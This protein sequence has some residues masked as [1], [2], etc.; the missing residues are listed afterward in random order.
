MNQQRAVTL[1]ENLHRCTKILVTVMV[2][3]GLQFMSTPG[4]FGQSPDAPKKKFKIL[5]VMSYH[6]PWVWTQ[7]QLNGF[8][9]ALRD[10]N[11]E[12][13]VFQL[14]TKR[15]NSDE[16]RKSA[17]KAARDLIDTWH[18]DLVYTNDDDAQKYVTKY[19]VG[20]NIPF[21]FSAVNADPEK[22]GFVGSKNITGV[23]EQEHFVES[24]QLLREIVPDVRK[25]AAVFDD[26]STWPAVIERMKSKLDQI[27]EVEIVNWDIIKTF[28]EYKDKMK[29][30]EHQVDAVALIGVF[31]FK[32]AAGENVP[33]QEVLQWTAENSTLPDFS[34]WKSRI[35]FGTLCTVTVSG[36]EQGLAAGKMA[37]SILVEGRSPSSFS[38]QP[39]IK[40]EPVISLA[41]ARRLGLN[42]KTG[43]LLSGQV[44]EKFQWEVQ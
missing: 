3:L 6:L 14:D 20:S 16:W 34:F 23:L 25:I 17:G 44:I 24:V 36:Y 2:A 4:A 21:V 32:D 1:P 9:D 35:P 26:G 40:G 31:T 5:H 11:V 30:Y 10:L 29:Q 7:D 15:H 8:K 41:R 43:V 22:Y 39:T 38:M 12:Y 13:K 33:Y 19:Y 42:I 28:Q 37:R 27:P 18:P